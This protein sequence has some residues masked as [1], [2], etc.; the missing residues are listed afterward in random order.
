MDEKYVRKI[1]TYGNRGEYGKYGFR[2]AYLDEDSSVYY[3]N[4]EKISQLYNEYV[5]ISKD[6]KIS[7][8]IVDKYYKIYENEINRFNSQT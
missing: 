5:K 8:D 3:K 1:K 6:N 7:D 2:G 4:K